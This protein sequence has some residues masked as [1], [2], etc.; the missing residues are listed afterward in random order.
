MVKLGI[1]LSILYVILG[2]YFINLAFE[3]IVLPASIALMNKWIFAVSGVLL[4]LGAYFFSKS[5]KK[6]LDF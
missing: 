1:V 6:E 5:K 2:L 3:V 4:L